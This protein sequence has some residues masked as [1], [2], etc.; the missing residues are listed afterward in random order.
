VTHAIAANRLTNSAALA[1][2]IALGSVSPE[3]ASAVGDGALAPMIVDK[4]AGRP[5]S[6]NQSANSTRPAIA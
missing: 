2:V 4:C 3:S 5:S 1:V 6:I